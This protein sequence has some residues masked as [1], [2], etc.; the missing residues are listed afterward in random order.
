MKRYTVSVILLL[1]LLVTSTLQAQVSLGTQPVAWRLDGDLVESL[2]FNALSE[3]NTDLLV[4]EDL[5]ADSNKDGPMRFA[6]KRSVD[7]DLDNSGRWTNLP[8]GDRIWM[9][10]LRS[11]DAIALSL[12]F[13]VF[14]IPKGAVVHIY[15]PAG[16]EVIGALTSENNKSTGV[17]TTNRITGDELVLEYY[18]PF[19]VRQEGDIHVRTIAHSYRDVSAI[20]QSDVAACLQDVICEDDQQVKDLSRAVTLIT[21]DEGTRHATG[22]MLNNANFDG[23]PYVLTNARNLWGDPESWLFTFNYRQNVCNGSSLKR[24]DQSISGA[25]IVEIDPNASMV[26]LELSTRPLPDWRVYYAGWDVSGATPQT[27]RTIDHPFGAGQKYALSEQAPGHALW[28]GTDVFRVNTWNSGATADGSCGAPMI[29]QNGRVIGVFFGGSASCSD[30]GADHY[31]KLENGHSSF[32]KYLDPFHQD[33]MTLDGTFLRFGEVNEGAFEESIALFPNP[34]SNSF[35]LLNESDEALI[36]VQV[37]DSGGRLVNE[38]NYTGQPI[39]VAELPVGYYIIRVQLETRS[40]QRK[41][42]VW[43]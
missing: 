16:N 8:N 7:Y 41:L 11:P 26:L 32:R 10:G 23:T 22:V 37:F 19:A 21:V 20:L 9:L 29:D 38:V 39:Q 25:S 3:V 30:E 36:A 42:M 18:E 27:V 13:D 24:A 4:A 35:N 15:D 14:D 12:T 1:A 5:I 28:Q 6:L 43:R 33:L 34:A 2:S 40:I 17:L 31:A